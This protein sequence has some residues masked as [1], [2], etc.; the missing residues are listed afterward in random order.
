MSQRCKTPDVSLFQPHAR[1]HTSQDEYHDCSCTDR[2]TDDELEK[3][4]DLYGPTEASAAAA[5]RLDCWRRGFA[6]T[7][8]LARSRL[9]SRLCERRSERAALCEDRRHFSALT[10]DAE[11]QGKEWRVNRQTNLTTPAGASMWHT[12]FDRM[13]QDAAD[14]LAA[15]EAYVALCDACASIRFPAT[16]EDEALAEEVRGHFMRSQLLS[17]EFV[18][19]LLNRH[20]TAILSRKPAVRFVD[21]LRQHAAVPTTDFLQALQRHTSKILRAA[22]IA[23][24]RKRRQGA[25]GASSDPDA[26]A[27]S[28]RGP[29]AHEVENLMKRLHK[30]LGG[31]GGGAPT[32]LSPATATMLE[33]AK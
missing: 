1:P 18:L 32:G 19:D 6:K 27:S 25:V 33:K 21:L 2:S 15:R 31:G 17:P 11:S 30:L 5:E 26:F 24:D 9:E 13:G 23:E 29:I 16:A 3:V 12:H 10:K 20:A 14:L 8:V 28:S 22:K 7:K 4:P